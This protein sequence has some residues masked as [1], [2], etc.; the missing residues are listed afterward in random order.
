MRGSPAI[1]ATPVAC[2]ALLTG[3]PAPAECRPP[4]FRI[5]QDYCGSVF[6]SI[7]RRDFAIKKLICLA[8]TL[9]RD[10]GTFGVEFFDSYEAAQ[11]FRGMPPE[12]GPPTTWYDW[13]KEVHAGYSFDVAKHEESIDISPMGDNTA[14]S[15]FTRISLPL[16][17]AAHCRLEIQDRCLMAAMEKITYPQEALKMRASGVVT[18][19]GTMQ[20]DGR[21][22]G[23]RVAEADVKPPQG[24][25]QLVAAALQDLKT[26]QFDTA[27]HEDAIRIA[28]S[29]AIDTALPRGAPAQAR[30]VSPNRVEVRADPVE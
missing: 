4:H 30:W 12:G 16:A 23:L 2:L 5:G 24:R 10:R 6:V 26:W 11:S 8:Q 19:A 9:R 17:G 20:R 15:W 29:F 22:A 21:V 27:A 13:A 18:L 1:G 3:V 28:Y 14:P 7:D 25:E